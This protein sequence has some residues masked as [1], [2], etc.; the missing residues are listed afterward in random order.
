MKPTLSNKATILKHSKS[1][2]REIMDFAN[3]AYFKTIGLDPAAVISFAGG[4]VNH[5]SPKELQQSYINIVKDADRFHLTGSYSPTIGFPECRQSIVHYEEYLFNMAG[6]R[7]ENIV[8][9][10]N[11]TQ[12]TTNLMHVLLDHGDKVLLLDPSYCNYPAQIASVTDADILRFPVID[13][14]SWSYIADQVIDDFIQFILECKPKVILL[15]SPDNPTSQVPS[16]KFVSATLAAATEIGSFLVI[17]FAY[18]EILFSNCYPAYYSWPPN[19]NYI[20][21]R[22]NSKWCRGLGRRMGWIEAPHWI[23]ELLDSVQAASILCPDS[24]HQMAFVEYTETAIKDNLLKPYLSDV[25]RRYKKASEITQA[26]IHSYLGLPCLESQGGLYNCIKTG[27][28]GSHF[29][30]RVLKNTGVLF[31]PGW[32]FGETLRNAVRIS[33]GPL[34]D[35]LEK[36]EFAL[37][38]VGQFLHA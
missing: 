13:T 12:L 20:S 18:K 16:D 4:W 27:D 14:N 33:C 37:Q 10:A 19:D 22:S 2:V 17:D 28:D 29:V 9:G 26:G 23:V 24:L 5:K 34:V 35:D 3:P 25:N 30:D 7:P 36:I 8:I 32:G 1:P 6:L 21:L 38:K 31:V 15:V 11:S